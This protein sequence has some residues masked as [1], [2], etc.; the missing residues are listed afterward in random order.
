M[1]M[2]ASMGTGMEE[3]SSRAT[4]PAPQKPSLMMAGSSTNFHFARICV[5]NRLKRVP[6]PPAQPSIQKELLYG[7][8]SSWMPGRACAN[9]GVKRCGSHGFAA[10]RKDERIEGKDSRRGPPGHGAQRGFRPHECP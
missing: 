9:T 3:E 10:I 6:L 4:A 8:H 1:A 7:A 2:I 5:K